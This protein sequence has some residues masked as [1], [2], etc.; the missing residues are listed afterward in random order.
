MENSLARTASSKILLALLEPRPIGSTSTRSVTIWPEAWW[1]RSMISPVAGSKPPHR[2]NGSFKTSAEI[3][4]FPPTVLPEVWQWQNWPELFFTDLGG[5]PR[6]EGTTSIG[7]VVGLFAFYLTF[8][9]TAL[10]PQSKEKGLARKTAII[11][12]A[13]A[14]LAASYLIALYLALFAGA[15]LTLQIT[16]AVAMAV[17]MYI[18]LGL[19]AMSI[20][21]KRA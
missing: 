14:I 20:R 9:L 15:S 17:L 3:T 6:P 10:S 18:A 12:A 11:I 21:R 4:A 1:R 19:L 7:V 13:L 8:F 2:L 5:Y 16:T